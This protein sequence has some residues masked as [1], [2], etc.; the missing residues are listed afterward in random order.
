[1]S[2]VIYVGMDVHKDHTSL[3]CFE[4]TFTADRQGGKEF[5]ATR[6][7]TSAKKVRSYLETISKKNGKR[8][9]LP[10]GHFSMRTS[11]QNGRFFMARYSQERKGELIRE[12]QARGLSRSKV[13][14]P[15]G[16]L[17][18]NDEAERSP[19]KIQYTTSPFPKIIC[20][21]ESVSDGSYAIS[22]SNQEK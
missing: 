16:R 7:A 5:C 20:P 18:K 21:C 4:P 19:D 3:V 15:V 17:R 1:M 6:V 8:S 2:K 13:S 11:R 12:W 9:P 22:L 10:K 14:V